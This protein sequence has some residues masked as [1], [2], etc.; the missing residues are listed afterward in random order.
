MGTKRDKTA[1]WGAVALVLLQ[2]A[3]SVEDD[4]DVLLKAGDLAAQ[5]NW[6]VNLPMCSNKTT[7]NPP[8][9]P[10]SDW[11]GDTCT[12]FNWPTTKLV[13]FLPPLNMSLDLWVGGG[14][15]YNIVHYSRPPEVS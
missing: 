8:A 2:A 1:I 4:R 5:L 14:G 10:K 15:N 7:W 11:K 6:T 9:L 12:L 13:L 3:T